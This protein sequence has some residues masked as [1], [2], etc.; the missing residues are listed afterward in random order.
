FSSDIKNQNFMLGQD[1]FQGSVRAYFMRL[2]TSATNPV[3]KPDL[4]LPEGSATPK[5][6][7]LVYA[8]AA[9]GAAAFFIDGVESAKATIAGDLSAWN[10]GYRLGLANEFSYDRAWL[11]E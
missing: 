3:G 4:G 11:G 1:E 7:H 2:R 10:D 6:I 8:R 5:L 9:S